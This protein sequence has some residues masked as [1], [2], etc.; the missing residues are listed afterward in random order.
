MYTIL[1]GRTSSADDGRCPFERSDTRLP[2]RG[3]R[4]L[5]TTEDTMR[6]C[7]QPAPAHSA[8]ARACRQL[9]MLRPGGDDGGGSTL[10]RVATSSE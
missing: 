7:A 5:P 9:V 2:T 10:G 4:K 6:A 8:F 3:R 1:E